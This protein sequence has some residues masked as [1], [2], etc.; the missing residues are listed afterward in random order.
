MKVTQETMTQRE[1]ER[2]RRLFSFQATQPKTG[3]FGS[4]FQI[5][6]TIKRWL[7]E[8]FVLTEEEKINAGIYIGHL[9]D[10]E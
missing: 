1:P 8:W 7:V 10:D 5:Y 3:L 4:L 6:C 2:E 9:G